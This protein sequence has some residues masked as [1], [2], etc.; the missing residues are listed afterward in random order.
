MDG[1][2]KLLIGIPLAALGW[3]EVRI[4]GKVSH[5]TFDATIIPMQEGQKRI[6]SHLYDLLKERRITPTMDVPDEIKNNGK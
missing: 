6:E 3:V 5:K 4:R 2:E 1:L